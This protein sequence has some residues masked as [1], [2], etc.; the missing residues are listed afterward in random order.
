LVL[1]RKISVGESILNM[2]RIWISNLKLMVWMESSRKNRLFKKMTL[3]IDFGYESY[4]LLKK[5]INDNQRDTWQVGVGPRGDA[6][7]NCAY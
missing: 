5:G 1:V 6:L 7:P 4:A 2:Q 3:Q